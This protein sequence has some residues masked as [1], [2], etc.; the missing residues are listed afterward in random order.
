MAIMNM[1]PGPSALS[2]LRNN[3]ANWWWRDAGLRK[4]ALGISVGFAGSV[5]M[6]AFISLGQAN[7]RL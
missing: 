7:Y 3:T 1:S 5:S 2:T 4:L 6:G